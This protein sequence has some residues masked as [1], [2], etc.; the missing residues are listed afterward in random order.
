MKPPKLEDPLCRWGALTVFLLVICLAATAQGQRQTVSAVAFGTSTQLGQTFNINVIIEGYSTP[1]DQKVLLDA[2]TK[3]GNEGLVEALE[4]MPAKGRINTPRTLGYDVKYIRVWSTPTGRKLRLVTDRIIAMGEVMRS[5]RSK[6]YSVSV[7]ELDLSKD[8]KKS[9]GTLLPA[10][11][12]KTNKQGE[13]EVE[14]FQ[15]PWRLGNITE[16]DK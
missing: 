6:D 9:A 10:C 1:E 15:N 14:A 8:D 2:F 16:W 7:I 13:I 11:K 12:L 3:G 5:T 4:K